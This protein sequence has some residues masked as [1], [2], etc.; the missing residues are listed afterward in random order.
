MVN[1][2]VKSNCSKS[3]SQLHQI[4]VK[5]WPF[6]DFFPKIP[7]Q[8]CRKWPD[9]KISVTLNW[10][11]AVFEEFVWTALTSASFDYCSKMADMGLKKPYY[12]M[13]AIEW[14]MF[15]MHEDD[16]RWPIYFC[17][18]VWP[19]FLLKYWLLWNDLLLFSKKFLGCFDIG[20][21]RVWQDQTK[22]FWLVDVKV[23]I[24]QW[25]H[26][27]QNVINKFWR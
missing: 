2:T 7:M 19:P 5:N 3:H 13:A 6:Q 10:S 26:R 12:S 11:S 8:N 22:N 16:R 23:T 21:F 27:R 9:I 4:Q 1:V 18:S 17:K 15:H 20:H 25:A 24:E 14:P